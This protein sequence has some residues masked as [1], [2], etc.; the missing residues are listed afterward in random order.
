[1][2][3]IINFSD[4]FDKKILESSGIETSDKV[5]S[6]NSSYTNNTINAILEDL[7]KEGE[8]LLNSFVGK[9]LNPEKSSQIK[10]YIK[11]YFL[12]SFKKKGLIDNTSFSVSL[13]L[14]EVIYNVFSGELQ[15]QKPI[16]QF[17]EREDF[18]GAANNSLARHMSLEFKSKKSPFNDTDFIKQA[19]FYYGVH[20]GKTHIDI[21]EIL[22]DNLTYYN[23]KL[24]GIHNVVQQA[25]PFISIVK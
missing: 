19:E 21:Y 16:N 9:E 2:A 7:S 20:F 11:Y 12:N 10:D 18:V 3:D 14:S 23:Y 4:Y 15:I 24:G 22:S 25:F 13:Y 6:I 17:L 5:D 8:N 1:M